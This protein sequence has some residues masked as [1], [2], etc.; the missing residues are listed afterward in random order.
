MLPFAHLD[1]DELRLALFE[2]SN[3]GSICFDP[4][5]LASLKFNPLLCESFKNFSLCKD[6]DPDANFYL[7]FLPERLVNSVFLELVNEEEIID[8]CSSFRSSAAPGFDN[9]S[10]GTIKQ[11][12]NCIISPLTSIFNLSITT[13]ALPDK[14]KIARVIPLYK[15]GAHNVFTNYRL[16]S[17]LPA[18]SKILEKIMY[19]HLLAF[20]DRHKILSDTQFGFRKNH[21][22]SY[23]LTKL[24]D[25][26]SCAIDNREITV[27]VF[28][29]LSKAFD[30]VDHNILH[31]KLEH[32]GIRGLA[33]NWFRSYLS[34]RHQYVE[35]NS[36][37][38][39]RQRIRCG[40]PQGSI[41]G[42]LLFLIYINDLCNVSNVL[43]FILL[44]M[45]RIYFFLI[46]I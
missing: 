18:F 33:L 40:V 24:Y 6:N 13:G 19:K 45:I 11:C 5:K 37:C 10:M 29:D 7:N 20:L 3:G 9:I 34:N 28:I 32:F 16:V 38:S 30:T 27:G 39:F 15:S 31:E 1:D 42:P 43:E 35:F 22:T 36:L 12:I 44:L 25:K 8:I 23:A 41:L 14:M 21:S 2:M 46:K 17:I 26:I 4:D